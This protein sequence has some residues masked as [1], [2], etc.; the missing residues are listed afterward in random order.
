[1]GKAMMI[2]DLKRELLAAEH[3]LNTQYSFE[4]A[5]P[6]YLRCLEIIESAPEMRPQFSELLKSLFDANEVSDEP[7]AFLMHALRWPEV[8]EWAE[9]S[10]RRMSNPIADGRP[11]E[12]VIEAFN[13]E[14]ENKE[15]YEL[16]RKK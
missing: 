1:M 15:F 10:I 4:K 3:I 14:W 6:N 11:L 8:R 9:G 2:D 7:L 12:K 5:E 16:F 13:D